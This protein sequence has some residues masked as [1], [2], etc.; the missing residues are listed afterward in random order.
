VVLV[1]LDQGVR[2]WR[3]NQM[4]W[5]ADYIPPAFIRDDSGG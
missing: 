3:G 5:L 2:F 4:V 1:G